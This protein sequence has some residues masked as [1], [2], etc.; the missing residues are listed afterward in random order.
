MARI[1]DEGKRTKPTPTTPGGLFSRA[2]FGRGDTITN[3]HFHDITSTDIHHVT[4][5]EREEDLRAI[6]VAMARF[7]Q[8][9]ANEAAL[10]F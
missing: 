6:V 5:L 1:G 10:Q 8:L 2:T 9:K 4:S 7:Y 3:K